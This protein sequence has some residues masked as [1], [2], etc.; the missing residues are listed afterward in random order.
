MAQASK[1]GAPASEHPDFFDKTSEFLAKWQYVVFPLLIAMVG[2]IVYSNT[3]HVPF[4]YDDPRLIADNPGIR[5]LSFNQFPSD[6]PGTYNQAQSLFGTS[7]QVVFFTFFLNYKVSGL[8]VSGFHIVNNLI[9]IA[10]ALLVFWLVMLTLRTPFFSSRLQKISRLG[11]GL[12]AFFAGLLF[13]THPV[14]TEA[15]TYISQR[16]ASTGYA[17]LSGRPF[18]YIKSRMQR[19]ILLYIG[20]VICAVLAMR[21]KE[22]AYT[23]P[24]AIA[25]YEFTFFNG[26][27]RKR[28][29]NLMPIAATLVMIPLN[30]LGTSGSVST[31]IQTTRGDSG[32]FSSVDYLLTQFRVIVTYIRL[33]FI[34]VNQNLDYDYPLYNTYSNPNVFLS[35]VLLALIAGAGVYLYRRSSRNDPMLR[36]TAFGIFWFFIT[37]SVESSINPLGNLIEEYRLYLPSVGI[38]IALVGIVGAVWERWGAKRPRVNRVAI[39]VGLVMI[40]VLSVAAFERNAVWHDEIR[41]WQ[42]AAG[43]SPGKVRPHYNLGS[44]YIS[45]GEINKGIS[46]LRQALKI[47]PDFIAAS[48]NLGTAYMNIGQYDK[49]AETLAA[50]L[51]QDPDHT[52][53]NFSVGVYVPA[54]YNLGISYTKLG[55]F[56]KAAEAFTQVIALDP[57][58]YT[59]HYNLGICYQALGRNSEAVSEFRQ[60]L[61]INP[62]FEQA[63]KKLQELAP[64]A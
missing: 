14:Q 64:A 5:T 9:H 19:H 7:R 39:A 31:A 28:I 53:S 4:V 63:Q 11:S 35:F 16:F 22:I 49:A 8:S 50:A 51:A 40:A 12:L 23:L 37:L 36:L 34:P 1:K 26:E 43:K 15:V 25:L 62:G 6:D 17:I 58:H 13:A 52:S 55:Q 59:A 20:A 3:F 30:F 10:N 46:E 29:V 54:Y 47:Q 24:V 48:N 42:D 32:A 45:S 61:M 60:V 56:D 18:A 41:L 38:I 21:S 2:L 57:S 44:I 27:V 33:F